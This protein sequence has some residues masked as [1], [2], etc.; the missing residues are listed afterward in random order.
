MKS[1]MC[2]CLA[3]AALSAVSSVPVFAKG[4]PGNVTLIGELTPKPRARQQFEQGLKELAAWRASTNQRQVNAV[5]EQLTGDRAGTF[6]SVNRFMHWSELD[7]P[8]PSDAQAHAEFAKAMGDSVAGHVVRVYEEMPELSHPTLNHPAKYYEIET[9]HVPLDKQGRFAAAVARQREAID[10]T[11]AP[12][13]LTCVV[14]AEGGQF[15]TWIL[16][17]GHDSA[18]ELAGPYPDEIMRNAFGSTEASALVTEF[19][20]LTGGFF[21]EDVVKFRPD[22]SYFPAG[23]K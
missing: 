22:L 6:L 21:T 17:F 7:N 10:K 4:K 23:S 3:I 5:F 8:V 16:A 9:F 18:A 13:D 2:L 11:K 12:V 15:G 20:T 19:S 14:L 1:S